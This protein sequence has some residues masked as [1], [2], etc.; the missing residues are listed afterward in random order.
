[1]YIP[2]DSQAVVDAGI[3]SPKYAAAIEEYIDCNM[4]ADQYTASEMAMSSSKVMSLD[5]INSSIEEGWKRPVYFAMTA[6]TS[7]Y[8]GLYP[9]MQCTGMAYQLTPIKKTTHPSIISPNT[10][11]MYDVVTTKFRWG[12]LDQGKDLYL[13]ETVRRM[14]TTTRSTITDLAVALIDEGEYDKAR[15]VLDLMTEKLPTGNAPYSIQLGQ[16]IAQAYALI[17]EDCNSEA[18]TQKAIAILDKEI[19]SY[20]QYSIFCQSLDLNDYRRLSYNDQY[21]DQQYVMDL[22]ELYGILSSEEQ[23]KNKLEELRAR[24]LNFDRLLQFSQRGQQ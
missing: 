1:M 22:F 21:I 4:L 18:D 8:L 6:P 7:Y 5:I 16:R 2:V 13:D 23:T 9:Y 11:K 20:A 14:V 17:G 15:E 10:E 19:D 3:V 24:G 12:G